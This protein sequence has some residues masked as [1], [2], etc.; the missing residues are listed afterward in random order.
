MIH[1]YD[2]YQSEALWSYKAPDIVLALTATKE[3]KGYIMLD[4]S[5]CIRVLSPRNAPLQLIT[6]PPESA[7]ALEANAI[8][9][10]EAESDDEKGDNPASGTLVPISND[11]GFLEASENDKPVVR[12]EQLQQIFDSGP[13]RALPPVKDLFN[14][15]VNLYARKPRVVPVA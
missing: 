10:D 14:A 8:E 1:V 6:P 12:P 11:E 15:V 5:S 13:S 4:S 7:L 9:R 2:P 3:G